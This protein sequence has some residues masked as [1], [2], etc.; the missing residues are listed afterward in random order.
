MPTKDDVWLSPLGAG[1][2]NWGGVEALLE[3]SG[4][5]ADIHKGLEADYWGDATGAHFWGK[6]GCPVRRPIAAAVEC[7]DASWRTREPAGWDQQAKAQ[8][9]SFFG[10]QVSRSCW[11]Q[12]APEPQGRPLRPV[13]PGANQAAIVTGVVC[14]DLSASMLEHRGSHAVAQGAAQDIASAIGHSPDRV[15]VDAC[16]GPK[17]KLHVRV[18]SAWSEADGVMS[19][20]KQCPSKLQLNK[21]Q[22][23]FRKASG[24]GDAIASVI[25]SSCAF[26]KPR[27]QV[28]LHGEAAARA[29]QGGIGKSPADWGWQCAAGAVSQSTLDASM[30]RHGAPPSAAVPMPVRKPVQS[31]SAAPARGAPAAASAAPAARAPAP[32]RAAPKPKVALGTT[33]APQT[34]EEKRAL[35]AKRQ[36]LL[37]KKMK[38]PAPEDA[39]PPLAPAP[40]TLDEQISKVKRTLTINSYWR[41]GIHFTGSVGGV[42]QRHFENYE[43][44]IDAW[45][46]ATKTLRGYHMHASKLREVKRPCTIRCF[47]REKQLLVQ[48]KDEVMTCKARLGAGDSLEGDVTLPGFTGK[49]KLQR[50]EFGP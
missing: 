18:E 22:E 33:Q 29:G 47:K 37:Q 35:L 7:S 36:A 11:P 31:V 9:A 19:K 34:E 40:V 1:G 10:K 15:A 26:S 32:P 3:A 14:C 48:I 38:P 6:V 43:L 12:G 5:E 21:A 16:T 49:F 27:Q 23:A 2:T 50:D 25:G 24:L 44:M 13:N 20:L 28:T 4:S 17:L 8:F 30:S 41:G 46:E 45:D 42:T 39:P